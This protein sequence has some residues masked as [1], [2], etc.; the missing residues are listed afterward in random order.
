VQIFWGNLHIVQIFC[1]KYSHSANILGKIF[2]KCK[3]LGGNLHIVQIFL[4]KSL[5]S[6][7]IFGK[8]FT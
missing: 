7:N 8:I 5:H 6:A 2:T 4:G 3:Y 1:G